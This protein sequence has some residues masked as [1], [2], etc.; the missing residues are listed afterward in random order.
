MGM[1]SAS[2]SGGDAGGGGGGGWT[3][4]PESALA[5]DPAWAAAF[6]AVAGAFAGKPSVFELSS[7]R[8]PGAPLSGVERWARAQPVH[9]EIGVPLAL[10]AVSTAGQGGIWG[11]V[12]VVDHAGVGTLRIP[13][14]VQSTMVAPSGYGKTTVLGPVVRM[15]DKVNEAGRVE[16]IEMMGQARD[17]I[18]GA[19]EAVGGAVMAGGGG[20]GA[21]GSGGAGKSS[22]AE[23]E[24]AA[25]RRAAVGRMIRSGY[26]HGLTEDAG[27]PEGIRRALLD[28]GGVVGVLTAEP[29]LLIET[30][31]YRKDGGSLR[32]LLDG[33]GGDK[34]RVARATGYMVIPRACM[35]YAVIIQPSSFESFVE[36]QRANN[37]GGGLGEDS[38][39]GR[40]LYGRSWLTAVS[41]MVMAETAYGLSL[42]GTVGAGGV[43]GEKDAGIVG[44]LDERA[45]ASGELTG[46]CY[47]L[48]GRTNSYRARMGLRMGWEALAS[49]GD[50][51]GIEMPELPARDVMSLSA[52]ALGSYAQVQ[53]MRLGLM[54]AVQQMEAQYPGTERVFM[55]M[56]SRWTQHV[57][58]TAMLLALSVDPGTVD[59]PDWAVRDAGQRMCVWLAS[60]WAGR[61]RAYVANTIDEMVERAAKDNPK[62]V[63][64]SRIGTLLGVVRTA[65][66]EA[67][68]TGLG[69]SGFSFTKSFVVKRACR[70]GSSR[71]RATLAG[72]FS[73]TFDQLVA[74]GYLEVVVPEGPVGGGST[75]S[76]GGSGLSAADKLAAAQGAKKPVEDPKGPGKGGSGAH[77][78][79]GPV[80]GGDAGKS[81]GPVAG[82]AAPKRGGRPTVRFRLTQKGMVASA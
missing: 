21:G 10:V 14:I 42:P 53:N 9:L 52:D 4:T 60:L 24:A 82:A 70:Q 29:D 61:M 6:E 30:A 22:K 20:A 56:A 57:L 68:D 73:E 38:A 23:T 69:G 12:P 51:H 46:I 81:V 36:M 16:R 54:N 80:S 41:G 71:Q 13:G 11:Q 47:A 28:G 74:E 67:E 26:C 64:R 39:V 43:G 76:G 62:G 44:V 27:T 2:A 3:L 33:W 1:K 19:L 45:A 8:V 58:R 50:T 78:D 72:A 17:K 49:V 63:D 34:I 55:P 31:A 48:A 7:E 37:K 15:L 75:G 65:V 32:Y 5:A 59:I 40:G 79:P 25:E 77:G 35:P 18:L 66:T